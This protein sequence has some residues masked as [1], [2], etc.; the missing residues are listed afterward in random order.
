MSLVPL[1][2][3]LDVPPT[4]MEVHRTPSKRKVFL[5]GFVHFHVGGRVMGVSLFLRPSRLQNGGCRK[6]HVQ[7]V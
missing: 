5:Q 2:I 4:N 3:D 6:K 1:A 7:V